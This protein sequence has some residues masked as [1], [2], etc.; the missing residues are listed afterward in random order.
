MSEA[1]YE[2]VRAAVAEAS[3]GEALLADGF[4]DALIGTCEGWF[5]NARQTVALY[6]VAL[7]MRVLMESGMEEEEEA[8]EW[9]DFNV[10]GAYVGPTTPVF[11]SIHRHP[12]VLAPGG[13]E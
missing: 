13:P 3:D 9:I 5:G 1:S 11:A 7:C 8:A 6:D 10:T 4:E 12:V 2:D